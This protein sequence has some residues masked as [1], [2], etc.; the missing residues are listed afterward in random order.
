MIKL[1]VGTKGT[2]KTKILID[3]M[4]KSERESN[5]SVVCIDKG[6][7]LRFTAN[8]TIRLIDIEDYGISGHETFAGFIL[9]VL[10]ENY[11]ITDIFIDS[12]IKIVGRD[13]DKLENFF[14]GINNHAK[15]VN[16][17]FTVSADLSELPEN[18]KK[19]AIT[20]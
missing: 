16:I 3:M 6:S 7:K 9:G 2:G 15:D 17:V 5:G 4:E 1:I 13:L 11:D 19:L 20:N 14:A 10:A 8:H 12:L 18:V